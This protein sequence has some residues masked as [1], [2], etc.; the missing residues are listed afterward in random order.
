MSEFN[1]GKG[2]AVVAE[3]LRPL[4]SIPEV[5]GSNPGPAVAPLGKALYPHCLVFRRRLY[6]RVIPYARKRTHFTSR[7]EQGE[8]PVKWSDSRNRQLLLGGEAY[9]S[10]L[11]SVT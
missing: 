11:L 6:R 2:G 8:I 7:K 5:P 1:K 4:T 10:H 9:G 3:R